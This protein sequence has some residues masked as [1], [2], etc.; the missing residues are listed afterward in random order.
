MWRMC[1]RATLRV[2]RLEKGETGEAGGREDFG[3]LLLEGKQQNSEDV[4]V[5]CCL[6]PGSAPSQ[7]PL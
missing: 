5:P 4:T 6:C 2:G 1:S 3:I 7:Q